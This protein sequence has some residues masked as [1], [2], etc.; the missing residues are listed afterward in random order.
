MSS[1]IIVDTIEKKTGDDV[2]LVGNLDVPTSYKITGT[3][4]DSIQAPGLITSA[5]GGLN[6]SLDNTTYN[7]TIG[8]SA[9]FPAG[10]MIYIGETRITSTAQS[11]TVS[12]WTKTG[13]GT[14][15]QN[16]DITIPAATVA[17]FSKIYVH[18]SHLFM[19]NSGTTFTLGETKFRR[20]N[21]NGDSDLG[22]RHIF[23]M[24]TSAHNFQ[25]S[26]NRFEVDTN[27]PSSGDVTYSVM[28]RK[29]HNIASY[30]GSIAPL[31]A[32]TDTTAIIMAYGIV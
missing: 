12:D 17:K 5:G 21:S 30:A 32:E 25:T 31:G 26:V 2:T 10:S 3:D 20:E 18:A 7:G 11:H 27:L 16:L 15:S 13:N 22:F 29:H 8:S 4:A 24:G 14:A 23:G 9:T 28:F 1:K 19:V 6:T